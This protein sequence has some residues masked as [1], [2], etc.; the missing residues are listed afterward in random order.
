M[1]ISR[2]F[3]WE[4]HQKADNSDST[5][6][7][8]SIRYVVVVICSLLDQGWQF[9]S[10]EPNLTHG[11]FAQGHHLKKGR[12]HISNGLQNK[13][14]SKQTNDNVYATKMLN[15]PWSFD[16][17]TFWSF[18]ENLCWPFVA[19]GQPTQAIILFIFGSLWQDLAH[20][21]CSMK[22]WWMDVERMSW[23]TK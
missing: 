6:L 13:Q 1:L 11:L 7:T 15:R 3:L 2:L 19:C 22:V 17:F 18:L 10:H 21:R 20:P 8:F 5:A 4:L 12:F 14:A 16:L 9:M 23:M